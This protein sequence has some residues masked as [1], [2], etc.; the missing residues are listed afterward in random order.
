MHRGAWNPRAHQARQPASVAGA[1]GLVFHSGTLL[2]PPR[3]PTPHGTCEF[4]MKSALVFSTSAAKLAANFARGMGGAHDFRHYPSTI[5]TRDNAPNTPVAVTSLIGDADMKRYEAEFP[6]APERLQLQVRQVT[7]EVPQDRQF[8]I[9]GALLAR[10][11]SAESSLDGSSS[12][13]GLTATTYPR[14]NA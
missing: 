5:S 11:P 8:A 4:A 7:P 12:D 13:I 9:R 14:G 3:A 1:V 6:V 10:F 2:A